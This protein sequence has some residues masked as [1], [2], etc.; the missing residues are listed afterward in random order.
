MSAFPNI[1]PPRKE[2]RSTQITPQT[3]HKLNTQQ[4][5]YTSVLYCGL[6]HYFENS[7][8]VPLNV[9]FFKFPDDPALS[10]QWKTALKLKVPAIPLNYAICSL[11]FV[12]S[13]FT[14]GPSGISLKSDAIP[15][16]NPTQKS[17]STYSVPQTQ[18]VSATIPLSS[19]V[20][21]RRIL[22][23]KCD[24]T[25]E[26]TSEGRLFNAAFEP[27]S[28][29]PKFLLLKKEKQSLNMLKTSMVKLKKKKSYYENIIKLRQKQLKELTNALNTIGG[30]CGITNLAKQV[31]STEAQIV[32]NLGEK[33]AKFIKERESVYLL[34]RKSKLN[35][36]SVAK[37]NLIQP[38][39]EGDGWM[40]EINI[41]IVDDDSNI[42]KQASI[43]VGLK[44]G[45]KEANSN[46]SESVT[47]E[48]TKFFKGKLKKLNEF[49]TAKL[50]KIKQLKGVLEKKIKIAQDLATT[51]ALTEQLG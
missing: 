26:D 14:V 6:C 7:S 44:A 41:E 4:Q 38:R 10:L 19:T 22:K 23:R 20:P 30:S 12:K 32:T 36:T 45:R 11:H 42:L 39:K 43:G 49:Q 5:A 2:P 9:Y 37:G 28:T 15:S 24:A 29:E 40:E 33:F 25:F 16:Y 17:L 50:Q 31:T 3:S 13:N 34:Q 35:K 21:I 8:E 47:S 27:S 1:H 46:I 51:L 18:N 48:K